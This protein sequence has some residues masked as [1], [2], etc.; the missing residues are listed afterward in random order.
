MYQKVCKDQNY[1]CLVHIIRGFHTKGRKLI[2]G[3]TG[4]SRK[5]PGG[6]EGS[7]KEPVLADY[8]RDY[9]KKQTELPNNAE[10]VEPEVRAFFCSLFF[11]GCINDPLAKAVT[12]KEILY[13]Y[14]KR[15]RPAFYMIPSRQNT[16]EAER[17][18]QFA[19][20][21]MERC[22]DLMGPGVE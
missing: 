21:M 10:H 18:V 12:G 14:D 22:I 15:G 8:E 5:R 3:I 17:Q 6:K 2:N 19:V 20:W 16:S 9:V 1:Y 4:Y 11:S 13:G 7:R